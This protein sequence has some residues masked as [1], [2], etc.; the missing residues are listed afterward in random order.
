M[1]SSDIV[2]TVLI[3]VL[4]IAIGETIEYVNYSRK[5]NPRQPDNV[6]I[7]NDYGTKFREA[8]KQPS[9]IGGKHD[10]FDWSWL[11]AGA[12]KYNDDGTLLSG[13]PIQVK[14]KKIPVVY[15]DPTKGQRTRPVPASEATS[16]D[17]LDA[18]DA[19]WD[20]AFELSDTMGNDL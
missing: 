15:G 12:R 7:F 10:E 9:R 8:Q 6:I 14:Q 11:R 4:L 13:G 18:S 1:K 3:V 20:R 17:P 19:A 16:G 2:L 5:L